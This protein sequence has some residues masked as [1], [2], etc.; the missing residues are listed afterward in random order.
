MKHYLFDRLPELKDEPFCDMLFTSSRL[1]SYELNT[2]TWVIEFV[3]LKMGSSYGKLQLY[4]ET[5]QEQTNIRD[6]WIS[7][8]CDLTFSGIMNGL[9]AIIAGRTEYVD[10]PPTSVV[11]YHKVCREHRNADRIA[12]KL[13]PLNPINFSRLSSDPET[14]KKR[15]KSIA[16][17]HMYLLQQM[18]NAAMPKILRKKLKEKIILTEEE[19]AMLPGEEA[20]VKRYTA[21][22]KEFGYVIS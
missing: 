12:E 1:D 2:R 3:L 18:P 19:L 5:D 17:I 22:I 15:S 7:G 6:S 21:E 13:P 14:A 11:A 10:F 8:L 20:K 9:Y 16:R 4:G